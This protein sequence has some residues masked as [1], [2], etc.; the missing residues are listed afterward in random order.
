MNFFQ[1]RAILKKAN[2]LDLTPVRIIKEETD[3]DNIVTLLV[4]KFTSK[5][6]AKYLQP[7]IKSP[8]IKM[9]LD[10]LGSASWLAIDGSKKV[11][12]IIVELE[13]TFGEK[14]TPASERFTKFLTILYDQKLIVYQ[15]ILGD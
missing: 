12:D 10:Q 11:A 5:F 13:K 14:I 15:E 4:P 6:G 2:F 8:Y 1:R 9:K 3:K 7:R